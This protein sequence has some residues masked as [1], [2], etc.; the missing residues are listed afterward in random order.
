MTDTSLRCARTRTF[1]RLCLFCLCAALAVRAS[2]C[3]SLNTKEH[4]FELALVS[5]KK[6]HLFAF[7]DIVENVFVC[8]Q[9]ALFEFLFACLSFRTGT[10][11]RGGASRSTASRTPTCRSGCSRSSCASSTTWRWRA[12]RES[13]SPTYSPGGSRSRSSR[14]CSGWCVQRASHVTEATSRQG[15]G[16][17]QGMRGEECM[18]LTD[19][20]C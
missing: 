17:V 2:G 10:S 14:S 7:N 19:G 3:G 8:V 18:S 5:T 15:T 16:F 1:L 12:S 20:H 6:N 4:D 13:R 11:R 9:A